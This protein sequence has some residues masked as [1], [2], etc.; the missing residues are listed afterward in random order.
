M[1]SEETIA[2]RVPKAE[3]WELLHS[4]GLGELGEVLARRPLSPIR[5]RAPA[6][7]DAAGQGSESQ[8]AALAGSES[9]QASTPDS[10]QYSETLALLRAIRS[11]MSSMNR[12]IDR[13][14]GTSGQ[15]SSSHL[16]GATSSGVPGD[17][18]MDHRLPL[19]VW[20]N[21]ETAVAEDDDRSTRLVAESEDT[22]AVF[23][24][25]LT[26][27]LPAQMR[28]KLRR[29]FGMPDICH[30]KVPKLDPVV[31]QELPATAKK[32][33]GTLAG[34]QAKILDAVGPMVH[35]LEEAQKGTLTAE[36]AVKAAQCAL[37]LLGNAITH[38]SKE[39]RSRALR[40]LN[41]DLEGL[42]EVKAVFE[43][44]A[45]NLFGE[46]FPQKS[47]EYTDQ[48]K[49]LRKSK[50]APAKRR[51]FQRGHPQNGYNQ[52]RGGGHNRNRYQPYP[53]GGKGKE[54]TFQSQK[55]FQRNKLRD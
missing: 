28:S 27:C 32:A 3:T 6:D 50:G 26:Q 49:A 25:A 10:E 17:E 2:T 40:Q 42:V 35:L 5:D 14:E 1:S 33:D 45:P 39:R 44:A 16:E 11:E 29:E 12:R 52:V 37:W 38:I 55:K 24:S 53:P 43:D 34:T 9:R 21:D 8:Q 51:D 30:T 46:K 15:G 20:D 41:E 19:P 48:V 13:L 4:I 23:K 31:K 36:A 7:R 22:E 18:P 54:N 47:K